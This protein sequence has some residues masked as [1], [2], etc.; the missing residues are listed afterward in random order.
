[1]NQK[2]H[3]R[4]LL[5]GIMAIALLLTTV[6]VP[7]DRTASEAA[8]KPKFSTKKI[9]VTEGKTKKLTVKNA[10]GGKLTWKVKNKK[11][12]SLVKSGKYAKK[13]KG[14][15]SGT[16]TVSCRVKKGRT[17]RTLKCTVKVTK[18]KT[19]TVGKTPNAAGN[20]EVTSSPGDSTIKNPASP[21]SIPPTTAGTP[22]P[23][24]VVTPTPK[25]A[26]TPTPKPA[27][28][29]T[30]KPVVTPTPKPTVTPT[31]KPAVTPTPTPV[32]TPTPEPVVTPTPEPGYTPEPLKESSFESGT[33]GFS[34][35]G[36]ATVSSVT[37]GYSGNC[38]KVTGR[39]EDWN[40][41]GFEAKDDV[42][43]GATY[44]LSAYV[45]LA[46]GTGQVKCTYET[47]A[48]GD[49]NS[50]Y[51]E[52]G[53]VDASTTW[54]QIT[55]YFTVP[56]SYE[57]FYL[58]FEVP[59]SATV[60]FYIDE[61]AFTRIT[62]GIQIDS[63]KDAYAGTFGMVGTCLTSSQMKDST[64]MK[65]VKKHYN[66]MT[67]EN[68]MK[69]DAI[70][71]TW[72]KSIVSTSSVTSNTEDYVIPAS[73]TETT[74]PTLHYDTVDA[75][76]KSA[77]DN[78]VKV[79]A[80]TLVWHSQTPDWFFKVGY[81]DSG[82]FVSTTVMD[83]RMEMYIRSVMHHVYTVD[84]G[85]YKDTVYVWDVANEYLNNSQDNRWSAVY[86]NRVASDDDT[87]SANENLLGNKPP[88]VKKAFEIAYDVLEEMNLTG[89]VKLFYNDFNTYYNSDQVVEL[90]NYIN[91]GET[92]KI[93]AGIGMQSHLDYG[94]PS[95][96]FYTD[97]IQ[98]FAD[99]GFEIQIT[100]LD[101]TI[102]NLYGSYK[103]EG[104][105][106]EQQAEY[107]GELMKAII[108]K[109]RAG[110][111]ITCLTLWGLYDEVS[112]RGGAQSGGNSHPLLFDTGLNDA[113]PSYY[114]FMDAIKEE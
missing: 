5:A 17:S 23:T 111:N 66:S 46:S 28:T 54:T 18:K 16:T 104:E 38:L 10:K 71:G 31:P 44:T 83:A 67:M 84:G 64:T 105:T 53:I 102:N 112:W 12:V 81:S 82:D 92:N 29:P 99:A 58:Y 56:A 41:A 60:D 35:R 6:L 39:T 52:I 26:V 62:K 110:A 72:N 42:V 27:V 8:V 86:G 21:T 61:V 49:T 80:H 89:S 93:C 107:F 33:D 22:T 15:K 37:G 43:A 14:K 79:R 70:L 100:E 30:P 94:V 20:D 40:G 2:Q 19:P 69:P 68:E 96:S 97:T 113:K 101:V 90:I 95:V 76:L 13:V 75:M 106:D 32:V 51:T 7:F 65:Y 63:I 114:A 34:G 73:Y 50:T 4:R 3:M 57:M 109:K 91:E 103:D 11:I 88:Y 25:P 98:K 36:A 59:D 85:K 55:G 108:A 1:M 87:S 24:P 9:T 45:K 47:K 77:Y 48:P 78:G 74:I